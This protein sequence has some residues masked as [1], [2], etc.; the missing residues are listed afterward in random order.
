MPGFLWRR[1]PEDTPWKGGY[2][3]GGLVILALAV[4]DLVSDPLS[5]QAFVYASGMTVFGLTMFI[6]PRAHRQAYRHGYLDAKKVLWVSYEEAR[7][8]GM[9]MHEWLEAER[10]R[11]RAMLLTMVID[12]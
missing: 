7:L 4:Y 8:R 11:D 10:D 5:F 12:P 9:D 6:W 3:A 2:L 1:R